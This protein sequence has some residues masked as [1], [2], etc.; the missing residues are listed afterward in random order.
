ML[1][2][3][4]LMLDFQGGSK[5]AFTELFARYRQ[6]IYG[7]FRRRLTDAGRAEELAQETR[8]YLH[9]GLAGIRVEMAGHERRSAPA[10]RGS[11]HDEWR[12][13]GRDD[14]PNGRSGQPQA[15]RNIA[16]KSVYN[17]LGTFCALATLP[18]WKA[19]SDLPTGD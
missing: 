4:Q 9:R 13:P 8:R 6:P 15:H 3:E 17:F 18:Y 5:E 7:Y 1:T 12:T 14:R 11:G 2:D 10:H 16:P 19:W